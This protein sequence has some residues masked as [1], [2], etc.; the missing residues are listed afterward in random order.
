MPRSDV[1]NI[2]SMAQR[3]LS[4]ANADL[5][6]ETKEVVNIGT[7][8]SFLN[9]RLAFTLEYFVA[10]TEDV[11]TEMPILLSTGND[12]GNP[13]V[14]AASIRNKGVEVTTTWKDQRPGG[15][16][17]SVTANFSTIRNEVLELGYGNEEVLSGITKTEIGEPIGMFFLRKTDGIFRSEEEVLN[18]VNSQG[19]IIQPNAKP[20]DIRYVD[21]DDNGRNQ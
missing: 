2:L 7:D 20:G 6:W 19:K 5:R 18:H 13:F 3:R 8:M 15:L 10:T 17:Y 14:N 1:T 4:L 11:L 12:G 16:R 9:N 21:A